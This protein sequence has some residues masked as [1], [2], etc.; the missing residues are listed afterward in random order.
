MILYTDGGFNKDGGYGSFRIETDKGELREFRR[1]NFPDYESA[2]VFKVLT[3]NEAEYS[4]LYHGLKICIQRGH[5]HINVF[6][7]SMLVVKQLQGTFRINKS[8]LKNWA[9]MIGALID[10]FVIFTITHVPRKIIVE[11]LGH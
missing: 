2:G 7:D 9:D 3:N 11:K 5:T 4:A 10:D 1:I 6:T 8:N